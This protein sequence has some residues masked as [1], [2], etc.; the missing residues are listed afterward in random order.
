MP[1]N[2]DWRNAR[3]RN[4]CGVDR[5]QAKCGSCWTFGTLSALADRFNIAQNNR[6]AEVMLSPQTVM[7]CVTKERGYRSDGCEGGQAAEVYAYAE[8]DGIPHESNAIYR[9]VSNASMYKVIR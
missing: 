4:Y 9:A 2:W 3:D 8:S 5:T 7:E 1:T 6:A